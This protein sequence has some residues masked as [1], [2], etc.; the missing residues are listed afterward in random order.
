MTA[1]S[2]ARRILYQRS[3]LEKIPLLAP[4]LGKPCLSRES[5]TCVQLAKPCGERSAKAVIMVCL[6]CRRPP[7]TS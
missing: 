6:H 7:M 4:Q 2:G 1:I 3:P 5:R